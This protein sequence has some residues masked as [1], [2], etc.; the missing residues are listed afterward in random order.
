MISSKNSAIGWMPCTGASSSS[1][2]HSPSG[3]SE[4]RLWRATVMSFE[5]NSTRFTRQMVA[6]LANREK[7]VSRR[8]VSNS[9]AI[10]T[11]S[12]KAWIC[13]RKGLRLSAP[14]SI[15]GKLAQAP[16]MLMIRRWE[17]MLIETTWKLEEVKIGEGAVDGRWCWSRKKKGSGWLSE[18]GRVIEEKG[19]NGQSWLVIWQR[20]ASGRPIPRPSRRFTMALPESCAM[21][22]IWLVCSSI[23]TRGE[24]SYPHSSYP[25]ILK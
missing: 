24:L 16:P 25:I 9:T 10:S 4:W 6:P 19:R 8:R 14:S 5:R 21:M 20:I 1:S 22:Q 17:K 2:L 11:K 15:K 18:E 13:Y 12:L 3:A 7:V 23:S